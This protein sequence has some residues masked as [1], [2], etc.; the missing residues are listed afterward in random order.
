M[1]KERRYSK[2]RL[3][4]FV[5]GIDADQILIKSIDAV[6]EQATKDFG[7]RFGI[8]NFSG[9]NSVKSFAMEKLGW[10]EQVANDYEEWVWTD[11][12]V[13]RKAP[14]VPGAQ[15]FTK[16]LSQFGIPYF[17]ITSRIPK[18]RDS[19]MD[20]FVNEHMPWIKEE[21]ILINNDESI[22]GEVFKYRSINNKGVTLHIEDSIRHARLILENTN[23]QVILASNYE[24]VS[25][26]SHPRLIKISK[27]EKTPNMWDV[28]KKLL[29]DD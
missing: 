3:S 22:E 23:S 17:V 8:E 19:T 29:L 4:R 11:E 21:Q 25:E 16:R 27:D 14:P 9:W 2:E 1:S 24:G 28:Y 15:A 13:L 6:S 7:I 5:Y 20:W 18:L 26:L 10:Q 12:D